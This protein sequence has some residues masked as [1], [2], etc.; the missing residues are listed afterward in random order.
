[1]PP[2]NIGLAQLSDHFLLITV[3]F[4]ALAVLAF[5]GDFAYGRRTKPRVATGTTS[6]EVVPAETEAVAGAERAR[7][8]VAAGVTAQAGSS[9]PVSGA[10]TTVSENS[11]N[12]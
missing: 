4:Y 8:G 9:V 10:S 1:M 2:V 5:A 6:A 11:L 7:V 12:F 3:F